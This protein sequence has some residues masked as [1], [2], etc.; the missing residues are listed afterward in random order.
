M[1]DATQ[2]VVAV[3]FAVGWSSSKGNGSLLRQALMRT[4]SIIVADIL[5]QN[6]T[7]VGL[8]RDKYLVE[9]FGAHS[10]Y[11]ALGDSISIGGTI[12]CQDGLHAF[13]SKYGFK[14]RSEL[15]ISI[16]DQ[17]RMRLACSWSGQVNCL[18]CWVTQA[19][20]G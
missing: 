13:G 19:E 12:R 18:A 3:Y 11:P 6:A 8:I 20:S 7:E 10:A 9:A 15:G 4:C 1:K 14:G 16:M 17:N 2:N 5:G